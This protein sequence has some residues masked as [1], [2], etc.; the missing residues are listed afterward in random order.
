MK[1][2]Q[3]FQRAYFYFFKDSPNVT[4]KIIAFCVFHKFVKSSEFMNGGILMV[5]ET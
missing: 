1:K 4:V 2:N 3:Y 5:K